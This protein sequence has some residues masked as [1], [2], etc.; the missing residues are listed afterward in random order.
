MLRQDMPRL[1]SGRA[2]NR[3]SGCNKSFALY[4]AAVAQTGPAQPDL[5][6]LSLS[7]FLCLFLPLS[8]PLS[9]LPGFLLAKSTD[10]LTA[11]L[12]RPLTSLKGDNVT[13]CLPT[14]IQLIKLHLNQHP[15]FFPQVPSPE[16]VLPHVAQL[17]LLRLELL[18][19]FHHVAQLELLRVAPQGP[20][21]GG[22]QG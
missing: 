19:V 16:R 17:E 9:V 13:G 14:H 18:R 1:A 8:L 22:M 2:R 4:F 12:A 5:Q 20:C 7:L 15:L 11:Q 21:L 10:S 3:A 6:S